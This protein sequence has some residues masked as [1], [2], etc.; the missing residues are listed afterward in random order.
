MSFNALAKTARIVVLDEGKIL[1]CRQK[2]QFW[3]F[4]P[5]WDI[6]Y[7]EKAETTITQK[8]EEEL[9]CLIENSFYIG[10]AKYDYQKISG[11]IESGFE[12][13]YKVEL[14]RDLESFKQ[15]GIDFI[16]IRKEQLSEKEIYP[17]NLK[18]HLLEWLDNE[19]VFLAT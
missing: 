7:G 1:F 3:H 17:K 14:D 5:G 9:G 2:D 10:A 12:I 13:I 8:V 4:L 6:G 15:D 19:K 11:K 16:W 18:S